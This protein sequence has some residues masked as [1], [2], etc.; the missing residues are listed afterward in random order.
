MDGTRFDAATKSLANGVS[1]RTVLRGLF[2]G[3]AAA[4]TARALPAAACIPPGPLNYCN[5]DSECCNDSRCING[6]C[7]CPA[8]K[9]KCGDRCID[10]ALTCGP[11]Y[12]P[13]GYR[14]CG[15]Q[16]IDTTRDRNNC[17]SCG[18]VCPV[19]QTCSNSHCCPK[20]KVYCDGTCKLASQC[21]L[22]S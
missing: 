19:T 21:T 6:I 7:Q 10:Q 8:G 17:G 5:A 3:L 18:H 4:V 22:V 1:R 12:C 11:Q 9:K 20:G 2:A 13:A 15:A 16:C 14:Q